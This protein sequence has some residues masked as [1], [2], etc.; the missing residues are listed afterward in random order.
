MRTGSITWQRNQ[1]VPADV[2]AKRV[3]ASVRVIEQHYEKP[4]KREEMEK[5]RRPYIDDLSLGEGGP[6]E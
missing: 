3:N 6:G 4:D 2:V 1:G 5:R